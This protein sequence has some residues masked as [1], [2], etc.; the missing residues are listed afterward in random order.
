MSIAA[1]V[2]RVRQ[3][4]RFYTRLVGALGDGHL[5][6]PYSLAQVRVLYEI[7]HQKTPAASDLGRDLGLDAGY[8]SRML[9]GF[10]NHKLIK[11]VASE[12]DARRSHLE[13]TPGGRKVFNDLQKRARAAIHDILEPLGDGARR[14]LVVAMRVIEDKLGRVDTREP[15]VLR[16]HRIGDMG[17]ITARQAIV[18]AEEY[19]WNDGYEAL[20]ARV[21][22]DFIENFEPGKEYCWVAER[23]GTMLGSVFVVRHRERPGVARLRLLYVESSARGLGVGRKLVQE[24]T[25]FAKSA[26]YHTLTLWTQSILKS[27]HRIYEAEGYALVHEQPNHMFGKDLVSQTWE[28][29]LTESKP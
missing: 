5:D 23:N 21:T 19:G 8:L 18:Y 16:P 28:L 24:C 12:T 27:A 17:M 15:V 22:A 25:R 7:A 2:D 11:R 13:L 14:E 26:G 9:K 10:E 6:S 3:F 29:D 4:N 1:D 20:V